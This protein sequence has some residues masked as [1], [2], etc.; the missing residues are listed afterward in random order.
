MEKL[1][2]KLSK[3]LPAVLCV[4]FSIILYIILLIYSDDSD[5]YFEIMDGKD[6]LNGNF[7]TATHLNDFPRIVQ[8]WLYAVCLA[9]VDNFG[10]C[11]RM[12]FVLLQDTIL[13]WLSSI[14]IYNK[15]N[16]KYKAIYGSFIALLIC[17]G[18]LVNIRPQIITMILLVAELI[19][20]EKFK[21]TSS[22][23]Y[24]LFTIPLAILEANFHQSLL[25]YHIF[26][27]V[28]YC[29]N[30][31]KYPKTFKDLISIINWK[32]VSMVPIY[33]LCSF[34]TPYKVEGA[35]FIINTFKSKVHQILPI[36][37]MLPCTITSNIGITLVLCLSVVILLN[38]FHKSNIFINFFTFS[39]VFLS[40][41][42]TRQILLL[43]ISLLYII[44]SLNISNKY[45]SK[46]K[47]YILCF[48]LIFCASSAEAHMQSKLMTNM[49]RPDYNIEQIITNKSAYIYNSNINI[50][51]Y[52][53]YLGYNK[54]KFDV[55][56]ET[57][58]EEVSGIPNLTEDLYIIR[59]GHRPEYSKNYFVSNEEIYNML[60]EYDYVISFRGDYVNKVLAESENWKK[61]S[62][63]DK[64]DVCIT[65]EHIT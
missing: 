6:I 34:L 38:Y 35:L 43:Y 5:M 8:Q 42:N 19:L 64:E 55:R 41:I 63:I 4:A 13:I 57:Y 36:N 14:F 11:G 26:I 47:Y 44:I 50:G 45:I 48:I 12:L 51:N 33:I 59:T 65:W 24:L 56:I 53:E 23:K 28:P 27:L 22:Y 37:E 15:T 16:D 7:Y 58:S 40:F 10:K 20:L 54:V 60:E 46:F 17:S 2:T 49:N 3:K 21:E 39:T 62:P 32:I 1:Y 25:I 29:I 61:V 31:I 52:L 30:D 9:L 18:Y